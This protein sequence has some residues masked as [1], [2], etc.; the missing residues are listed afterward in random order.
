VG[1][2][3]ADNNAATPCT[4]CVAG[5]HWQATNG[6]NGTAICFNCPAGKF[7]AKPEDA[8][9]ACSAGTYAGVGYSKCE[10]CSDSNKVDDDGDPAT[11]CVS[12]GASVAIQANLTLNIDVASIP[13]G[14]KQRAAFE[15]AFMADMGQLLGVKASRI[16]VLTVTAGSAVVT[17]EVLPASNGQPFDKTSLKRTLTTAVSSTAKLAG[18]KMTSLGAVGAVMIAAGTGQQICPQGQEDADLDVGTPCTPC[19]A[20]LYAAGGRYLDGVTSCLPCTQ[21]KAGFHAPEGSL[22]SA[23]Q[24]CASGFA[25][26]DQNTWTGCKSCD[27][28]TTAATVKADGTIQYVL[29]N[30]TMCEKCLAGLADTDSNSSTKCAKCPAGYYAPKQSTLCTKCDL[31]RYDHDHGTIQISASTE[32]QY[33]PAGRF[34][35]EHDAGLTCKQCRRGKFNDLLGAN[36]S[37]ACR[38]CANGTWAFTNGSASC[39]RCPASTFR[40]SVDIGCQPCSYAAFRCEE[41]GMKIPSAA[42]GYFVGHNVRTEYATA[43]LETL[44]KQYHACMPFE[45]CIG[46]CERTKIGQSILK[47]EPPEYSKCPG[48]RGQD[49]CAKGY[50]G[51]RCSECEKYNGDIECDPD[52]D[53][54]E[55]NG[56]YR[57]FEVS[58]LSQEVERRIH[59]C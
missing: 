51:D 58:H 4:P 14:S 26:Q 33:C 5:Q 31:G 3:D 57:L 43:P 24:S 22:A 20:G 42:A 56:Y 16:Q 10:D 30:A 55:P 13:A 7:S 19:A 41:R 28:G 35:E 2:S 54:A 6:P 11:P 8:C 52:N 25:D 21:G 18:A 38:P 29:E 48:A 15:T 46:S 9:A 44:K 45:G 53:D 39:E 59:T 49:S 12:T 36:S 50:R 1:Q 40:R 32:C 37:H 34:R 17:F 23:C 47:A 27:P